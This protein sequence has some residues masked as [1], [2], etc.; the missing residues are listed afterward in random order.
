MELQLQRFKGSL[1]GL[2]VG[3][4]LGTT[5]EFSMPGRFEPVEDM[6]GGGP[7]GLKPGQWTDDTSMAICLA[8]S[9]LETGVFDPVDQMRR[10]ARWRYEGYWS[11]TGVCF[12]VGNATAEA[13]GRFRQT[14]E[15]YCGSADP[16]SAGNGSI[17]Y[18]A[19][20]RHP[21]RFTLPFG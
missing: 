4:A 2:A 16:R 20:S 11:S 12:D 19:S 5:I 13:I 18:S 14:G 8:E 7:F 9:L 17:L 1:V 3:D 6:V 21:L 10:Y 15:G